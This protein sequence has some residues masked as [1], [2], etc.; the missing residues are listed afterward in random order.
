M[1]SRSVAKTGVQWCNLGSLQPQPPGLKQFS[2]LS[3][4]S[5]WDYRFFLVETG[6][7]HVG[8]TALKLLTSN[9]LPSSASRS[10]GITGVSHCAQPGL[11]DF[12]W[13]LDLYGLKILLSPFPGCLPKAG[14]SDLGF[15]CLDPSGFFYLGSISSFPESISSKI[16]ELLLGKA[17]VILSIERNITKPEHTHLSVMVGGIVEA[18]LGANM[19]IQCPVKEKLMNS[20]KLRHAIFLR[21]RRRRSFALIAEAG[22]QWRDLSSRN[23]RLT[24]SSNSPA[25]ASRRWGFLM[26][27]RLVLNSRPQVIHLPRLPKVLGLQV[28]GLALLPRLEGSVE[29]GFYHVAQAGLEFLT[30][31][32]P[33][34]SA[35][36]SLEITGLS[37]GI[38][39]WKAF[40]LV[41]LLVVNICGR[42]KASRI[43]QR[44]K[45]KENYD[46]G[47]ESF[48]KPRGA[49]KHID[50]ASLLTKLQCRGMIIAH[51]SLK[52]LCSSNPP[53]LAPDRGLTVL[54]RLDQN[55]WPQAT[56][57]SRPPKVLR[58]QPINKTLEDNI[59]QELCSAHEICPVELKS[60]LGSHKAEAQVE[61]GFYHV[62]QAGLELLTSGDLPASASQN[63]EITGVSYHARPR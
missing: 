46:A 9:D 60:C 11:V 8:Q 34:N 6:F 20:S 39:P 44:T 4:L 25:S 5:S 22:V 14:P 62:A 33:S 45:E 15:L 37:H 48:A 2:C 59:Q 16:L 12:K 47:P 56:L 52:L 18:A 38:Q 36:Q 23:L 28:W 49:L 35:S 10:A 50:S 24:G 53:G 26:L 61:T 63:A 31:S 17:P 27:V 58:L 55:S 1:E 3:F 13:S 7:H 40:L 41:Y 32:D 51:C 19:T 21:R 54:P 30:S 42:E 57:P 43:R 29:T